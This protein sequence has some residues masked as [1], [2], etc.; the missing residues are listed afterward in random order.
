M[1]KTMRKKVR[2][3]LFGINPYKNHVAVLFQHIDSTF[4]LI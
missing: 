4:V 1:T 3:Y 2:K